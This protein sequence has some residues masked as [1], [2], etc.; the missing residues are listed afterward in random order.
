MDQIHFSTQVRKIWD[1]TSDGT[2]IT[3]DDAHMGVLAR[4]YMKHHGYQ[5]V[6]EIPRHHLD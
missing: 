2:K 6:N 1:I 3:V 5:S 4:R